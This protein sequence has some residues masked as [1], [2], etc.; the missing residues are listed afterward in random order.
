[1]ASSE[2][3]QAG[4]DVGFELG[5]LQTRE[6]V[7]VPGNGPGI[8]LVGRW[9]HLADVLPCAVHHAALHLTLRAHGDLVSLTTLHGTAITCLQCSESLLVGVLVRFTGSPALQRSAFRLAAQAVCP[10]EQ[11]AASARKTSRP[12]QPLP[13][14]TSAAHAKTTRLW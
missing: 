3:L 6:C 12:P 7:S 11:M 1:M 5:D 10:A 4:L 2:S 13:E 14:A 8:S 9:L